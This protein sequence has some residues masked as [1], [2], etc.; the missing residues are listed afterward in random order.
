[1]NLL[2]NRVDLSVDNF[3]VER[4]YTEFVN[5]L[6][7]YISSK[8]PVSNLIHLVYINGESILLDENHKIIEAKST[9][10]S[11]KYLSDITFSTN[12]YALN[13]LLTL[14]PK[15]LKIH[16]SS[17]KDEFIN[18]LESVFDKRVDFCNN[19]GLCKEIR[20]LRKERFI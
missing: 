6:K 1:M 19:C 7:I 14:L 17:E 5:L 9:V 10:L 18:T 16:L 11:A 12:D 3:L 15:T 13:T 8:P 4:E 2:D 20:I